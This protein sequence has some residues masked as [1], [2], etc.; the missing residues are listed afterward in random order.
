MPKEK[1]I[2][3]LHVEN[4]PVNVEKLEKYNAIQFGDQFD[5][6]VDNLPSNIRAIYF[7]QFFNQPLENLPSSIERI[8]FSNDSRVE[9]LFK[10]I[11]IINIMN[12]YEIKRSS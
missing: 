5:H 11:K 8:H 3:Y 1:Y 6:P 10:R 4:V 9:K 12:S 7:G 2:T